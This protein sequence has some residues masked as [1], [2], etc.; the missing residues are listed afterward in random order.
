[1]SAALHF[2]IIIVTS[3]IIFWSGRYF[4]I[5]SSRLGDYLRLPRSVKGVTFDAI[6]SSLPELL[7]ALFSVLIFHRFEVGVGTIAGSALF[8]LLIIPGLCVLLAPSAF[9]VSKEIVHRDAMFYI[10]SVF[11]L[12]VA[13]VYFKY[14][15]FLIGII[16][17]GIYLWY[18][19]VIYRDTKRH[20]KE[21]ALETPKDIKPRKEITTLLFHLVIIGF[22][23]YFLTESA[24]EFSTLIGV[25]AIIVAF[26]IVAAGT[27]VPDT[28]I[29]VVN[30]RKGDIDDAASNV[31]GSNIFDILIGLSI[32][33]LIAVFISGPALIDFSQME[34]IFGLLGATIL[35]LY[36]LAESHT[37]HKSQ[38]W[39]LLFMY[40][41]FLIYIVFLSLNKGIGIHIVRG[42]I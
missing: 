23:T 29:S 42:M 32:P 31:F 39:F 11:V 5:S 2:G 20:Q 27:S 30:A 16:F 22:S 41:V 21:V 19:G 37:I 3:L 1:M 24:I 34:I 26:T 15:G 18:V 36:F 25:P 12:L 9:K 35:V 10:I 6:S 14:W 4:A 13:L 33:L 38:A 40:L 8:N 28:V 7:I 17:L